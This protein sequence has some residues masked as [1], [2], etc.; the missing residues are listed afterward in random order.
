M[1]PVIRNRALPSIHRHLGVGMVAAVILVGG[2]GGWASTTELAGAVIAP[3]TLVVDSNVKKVQ[4]PSGGVIGELRVREG[5]PVKAGEVLVRLDETV[6]R[7]N[8]TII[9]KDLDEL[10]AKQARLEAERDGEER[11]SFPEILAMRA[12][13][14]AV[15]AVL[16]GE[17]KLFALRHAARAGQKAQLNERIGQLQEQ[18][19]GMTEQVDAK[20]REIELISEEL[21]GVREL[22]HKKLIPIVRVT[23][24]ERDKARLHGERGALISSIAQAKGKISETALQILQIDQDLRSD[25]SKELAEIRAKTSELVEKRVAAEDQLK[26]IDIRA[27]QDGRVHQLSVHTVG[28][29]ISPG[30]PIMLIVPGA[31]PL[32]VEARIAPQD[33]DQV[34]V[35]QQVLLRFPAFNL[36]TTPELHGEVIRVAADVSQDPKTGAAFYTVRVSLPD[37][38]VARLGSLKL[39]PGMPIEAF[40]HTGERTALSY[41]VKPLSDQIM[42]A[43]RER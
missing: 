13:D 3:G 1:T 14:P 5:D 19:Q 20:N 35:G 7:A 2:V 25:V 40:V 8:L 6:T 21:E 29:V 24:L 22:W 38:E 26:R 12:A 31:D 39:V 10:A 43:W 4:H 30:D 17:R 37:H 42:K 11:V 36:R 23:A 16:T 18:I 34:R 15:A 27:P 41:L 28:G 32:L 33:I 9:V